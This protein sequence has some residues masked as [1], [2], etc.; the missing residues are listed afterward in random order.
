[1]WPIGDYLHM[2]PACR[3]V[4]LCPSGL[5]HLG[6]M[7]SE[8]LLPETDPGS[9]VQCECDLFMDQHPYFPVSFPNGTHN[10]RQLPALPEFILSWGT[11]TRTCSRPADAPGKYKATL[12]RRALT[13]TRAFHDTHR[14]FT[15]IYPSAKTKIKTM[16]MM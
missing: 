8:S 14:N 5:K 16:L 11:G 4:L 1:M 10:P 6:L 7:N 13:S 9:L 3:T 15:Q 2:A 12:T